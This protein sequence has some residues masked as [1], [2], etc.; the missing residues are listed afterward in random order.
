M[1]PTINVT[2]IASPVRTPRGTRAFTCKT[3]ATKPGALPAKSTSAG[4]PSIS[5]DTGA[6]GIVNGRED[7]VI[8]PSTLGGSVCPAPVPKKISTLR[9]SAGFEVETSLEFGAKIGQ[10]PRLKKS[11]PGSSTSVK[12]PGLMSTTGSSSKFESFP[13]YSI[14]TVRLTAHWQAA[15]DC[16]SMA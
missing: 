4:N 6:T 12:I 8:I 7:P 9:I 2:G 5:S 10:Q 16:S 3:P 1:L 14:T 11:E 13:R 15:T